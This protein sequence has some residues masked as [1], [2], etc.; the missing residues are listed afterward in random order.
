[1]QGDEGILKPGEQK[2]GT[3]K[4]EQVRIQDEFPASR[5]QM[6]ID[7]FSN[8]RVMLPTLA[9]YGKFCGGQM[10]LQLLPEFFVRVKS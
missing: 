6:N 5:G 4:K 2:V 9:E 10:R 8:M 7:K 1:M 3:A